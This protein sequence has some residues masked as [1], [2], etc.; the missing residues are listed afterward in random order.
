VI[1]TAQVAAISRYVGTFVAG[2]ATAAAGWGIISTD[3]AATI[4]TSLGH[5]VNGVQEITVGVAPLAAVVLGWYGTWTASHKAQ[6]RAVA[7]TG[8]IIVATPQLAASTPEKNIV[9]SAEYKVVPK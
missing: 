1:T 9:S 2:A 8:A 6:A 5:I 7:A 4:Q 3:N